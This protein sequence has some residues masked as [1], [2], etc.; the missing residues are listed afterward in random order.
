M[1]VDSIGYH[2]LT[3]PDA[4][5]VIHDGRRITY[6]DFHR[7]I[8]RFVR[9]VAEL[10]LAPGSS[11]AVGCADFYAHWLLLLAFERL[12]VATASLGPREDLASASQLLPG[13]DLVLSETEVPAGIP[14]KRYEPITP[15][16]LRRIW[17]LAPQDAEPP[18][19]R[20]PNDVI[21]IL[22]TSG[23]TGV[24][25]RMLLL[26]RT[27]EAR[28]GKWIC[29]GIGRE[30]CFLISMPFTMHAVY[31]TA[32]ACVRS[33]ATIVHDAKREL[34]E[35]LSRFD[36]DHVI[37][38]PKQLRHV[39]DRLPADAARPRNLVISSLGATLPA[40]LRE[41]AL[42][43]MAAAVLDMYACNETALVAVTRFD[44]GPAQGILWPGVQIE[45]VDERDH[46]LP[47]GE[48][49]TI[50]IA[51]D[52][53]VDGYLDDPETT[54][55]MF[56]DGWFYPGDL[57]I[58]QGARQLQVLGRA[59]ELLNVGGEKISPANVE[60]LMLSQT[61]LADVGVCSIADAE[62][63]EQLCIALPGEAAT[64]RRLLARVEHLL[65]HVRIGAVF[66]VG[67][68]EIPRTE[69]GKIQRHLLKA[70]ALKAVRMAL[71]L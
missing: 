68:P 2:A 6:A 26:R 42:T 10:G 34:W 23:T 61:E 5:A 71:P 58:L 31:S 56:R 19:P 9:G 4:V 54:A 37:L 47:Y 43:R 69:T 8:W 35:A 21:R 57:G 17:T 49:G 33:G 36:I 24:S 3:R 25:R 70:A 53:T 15:S 59:D 20:R 52:S 32:T 65:R 51:T 55:R 41:R 48:T 18:A 1:T 46:R 39:L 38:M 7:D 66:V 64:D 67:V 45:I 30:H 22:R 13:M 50:R 44:G 27:H 12:G 63:L 11:V 14:I 62:G 28:I 60:E 16:W 29:F 40:P